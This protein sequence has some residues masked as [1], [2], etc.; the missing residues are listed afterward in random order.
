MQK[1]LDFLQI[2]QNLDKI[3]KVFRK[4]IGLSASSRNG[5]ALGRVIPFTDPLPLWTRSDRDNNTTST[6]TNRRKY[7]HK[8]DY[9]YK[10][11]RNPPSDIL[12]LWIRVNLD[13]NAQASKLH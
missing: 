3:A 1:E 4:A 11:N 12:A 13:N 5:G 9:K 10:Y 6:N 8:Y 2:I 7:K